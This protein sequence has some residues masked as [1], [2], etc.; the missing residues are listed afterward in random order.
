MW[1]PLLAIRA[2][3][4]SMCLVNVALSRPYTFVVLVLLLFL[5]GPVML[6]RTPVDIFPAIKVPI[7]SIIWT[8]T[9]MAPSEMETRITLITSAGSPAW[10]KTSNTWSHKRSMGLSLLTCIC[11]FTQVSIAPSQML[12]PK[13]IQTKV[14]HA[15]SGGVTNDL[16]LPA[17]TPKWLDRNITRRANS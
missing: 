11:N 17:A 4:A 1:P 6:L 13:Q 14:L 16:V 9:G 10:S 7:V 3:R 12:W 15:Q 5:L 2:K 8:Y